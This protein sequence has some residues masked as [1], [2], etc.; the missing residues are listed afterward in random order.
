MAEPGATA[1]TLIDW[2]KRLDPHGGTPDL[3][4]RLNQTRPMLV[5]SDLT[6]IHLEERIHLD[7]DVDWCVKNGWRF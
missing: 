7:D 2:A 5:R 4:A 6:A 1:L 3:V